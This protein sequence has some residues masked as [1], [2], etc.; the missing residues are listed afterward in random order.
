MQNVGFALHT[1]YQDGQSH[2]DYISI[3]GTLKELHDRILEQC[4]CEIISYENENPYVSF[5]IGG[6]IYNE[7]Y[8]WR[9]MCQVFLFGR[10]LKEIL[11]EK[12]EDFDDYILDF[13]SNEIQD[14]TTISLVLPESF[15]QHLNSGIPYIKQQFPKM[16]LHKPG[17][18]L[19]KEKFHWI[20]WDP[21]S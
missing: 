4:R 20:D 5:V 7:K 3:C 18:R 12:G 13:D 2:S 11:D 19:V 14:N 21:Y 8:D 1:F 9:Q 17:H 10:P 15:Q 6:K 16:L